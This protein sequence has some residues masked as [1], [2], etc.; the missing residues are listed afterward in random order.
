MRPHQLNH[1]T[2]PTTNMSI[3]F[4]LPVKPLILGIGIFLLVK[5][6]Q[7][8][9]RNRQFRAFALSKGAEN[10]VREKFKLP[11]AI[12]GLL[13]TLRAAR[14]GDKDIFEDIYVA[15]QRRLNRGSWYVVSTGNREVISTCDP[16]NI[17]AILSTQFEDFEQGALREAQLRVVLGRSIFNSDGEHW[18]RARALFRPVFSR[19]NINDLEATEH[20]IKVFLNLLPKKDGEWTGVVDLQPML[21]R[22]TLDTATAFIFGKSVESQTAAAETGVD[23]AFSKSFKDINEWI[24]VRVLLQQLYF[25]SNGKKFR[26]SVKVVRQFADQVI[27]MALKAKNAGGKKLEK[28]SVIDELVQSTDN[29]TEIRDQVLGTSSVQ[30]L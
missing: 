21:Y 16:R 29:P 12:D 10:P 13:E 2:P 3:L 9:Y 27:E 18:S 1:P 17:K 20:A 24:T 11:W 28:Y 30:I 26:H 22:F 6:I 14:T 25:L 23:D 8:L 15:R 19:S 7:T 5:I 4:G